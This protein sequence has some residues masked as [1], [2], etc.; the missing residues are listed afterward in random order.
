MSSRF[1]QESRLRL[2]KPSGSSSG[3]S[4]NST[5]HSNT[6][7]AWLREP[8]P[9]ARNSNKLVLTTLQENGP[10]LG[11]PHSET[12]LSGTPNSWR[13]KGRTLRD[14]SANSS[15]VGGSGS[16]GSSN[17]NIASNTMSSSGSGGM[18][19]LSGMGG[20]I[21]WTS[22]YYSCGSSEGS[23]P[24]SPTG[25]LPR[26]NPNGSS[27]ID[28]GGVLGGCYSQGDKD[29]GSPGPCG[30]G[31]ARPGSGRSKPVQ[32]LVDAVRSND[33]QEL[34][35]VIKYYTDPGGV[36]A[37]INDRHPG[38]YQTPL[39]EAVLMDKP[40]LV[41]R[42]LRAGGD[43]NLGH[44][45]GVGPLLQAAAV[46]QLAIVEQLL[47]AGADVHAKDGSENSALHFAMAQGH[48]DIA[49]LLLSRGSNWSVRNKN[50]QGPMDVAT[51]DAIMQ[52]CTV[53]GASRTGAYQPM[54]QQ[55]R[56]SD[57][58]A[59]TPNSIM[60]T[61]WIVPSSGRSS[62]SGCGPIPGSI[63][64]AGGGGAGLS[65]MSSLGTGSP[66]AAAMGTA[67]TGYGR[68][69]RLPSSAPSNPFP[70]ATS[71]LGAAAGGGG[72]AGHASSGTPRGT[73]PISPVGGQITK[74]SPRP[75]TDGRRPC[76]P[77]NP[78]EGP[79]PVRPRPPSASEPLSGK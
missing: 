61:G 71:G 69:P 20:A 2:P 54:L 24:P 46:G 59:L 37:G 18:V 62:Y 40:A 45:S 4:N 78:R 11:S 77:T 43:P 66:T 70:W 52:L 39:Y 27:P 50:G 51:P 63:T 35:K 79:G 34:D 22:P 26:L 17:I 13:S 64:S 7:G 16:L 68:V 32:C 10:P 36:V 53:R 15:S 9:P 28:D 55:G 73:P 41:D 67:P 60:T 14:P 38:C 47:D 8:H 42:L 12:L 44:V 58:G 25:P 1:C 74:G 6:G 31:A 30:V 76:P 65:P 56:S 49:R 5:P 23:F 48:V 21:R 19:G 72:M 57:P 29:F 75:L 3:G 33:L